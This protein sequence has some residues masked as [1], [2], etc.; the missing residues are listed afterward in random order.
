MKET[1][2][3]AKLFHDLYDGE[4][5][6]GVNILDTLSHISVE[7]AHTRVMPQ[8]NT[9]WEIVN[10]LIG[11]RENVLVRI[12]GKTIR[13][14]SHNYIQP[15][16]KPTEAAWNKTLDHLAESQIAWM[17]TLKNLKSADLEIIYPG[18]EMAYYENIH[19]VLQHDAYHLGQI[20]LLA[21]ALKN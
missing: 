21:K 1:Q 2:R 5:W 13:T 18:N 10:H 7:Q 20:V 19:G 14:P 6:I 16:K 3:I 15:I 9:V 11:W 12:S 4:A 8:W 17:A